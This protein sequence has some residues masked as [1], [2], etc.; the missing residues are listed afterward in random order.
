MGHWL[1]LVAAMLVAAVVLDPPVAG[2][3]DETAPARCADWPL[4]T[5][6]PPAA[7]C[8]SSYDEAARKSVGNGETITLDLADHFS[9]DDLSYSVLFSV[10]DADGATESGYLNSIIGSKLN[11]SVSGGTLSLTGATA[12][13]EAVTV[14]IVG[15]DSAD[16]SNNAAVYFDL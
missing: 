10:T 2:S 5:T 3:E 16:A 13:Y 14:D 7:T 8:P 11:G 6:N 1:L 9:G 12:D 15:V 4:V